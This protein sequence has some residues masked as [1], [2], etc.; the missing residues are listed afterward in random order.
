[1][2]DQHLQQVSFL[3]SGFKESQDMDKKTNL[4]IFYSAVKMYPLTAI[5]EAA[6]R[7]RSGMV[8]RSNHTFA[9]TSA[10]FA[11]EVRKV[12]DAQEARARPR[13]ARGPTFKSYN[14]LDKQEGLRRQYG[15]RPVIKENATIDEW[16]RMS[17]AREVPVGAIWVASLG[18]IYGPE[19]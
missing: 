16:H 19:H 17:R 1:M 13:L 11:I 6:S 4:A 8:E 10:E 15:H 5:E 18:T 2:T 3:L 14:F 12:A 7:F 9:P